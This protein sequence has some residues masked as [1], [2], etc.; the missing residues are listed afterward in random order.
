M[1]RMNFI[2]LLFFGYIV[3]SISS[4]NNGRGSK[5]QLVKDVENNNDFLVLTSLIESGQIGEA[6]EKAYV[7]HQEF[8]PVK[9]YAGHFTVNKT[10]NSN[11]FFWYF[12]AVVLFF[13]NYY[14]S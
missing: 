5:F 14:F 12:P 9:S 3:T 2:F 10:Y 13:I 8:S 6:R 7:R 1:Q 4:P 11:L